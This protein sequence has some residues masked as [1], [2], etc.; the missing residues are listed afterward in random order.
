LFKKK[1]DKKM[2]KIFILFFIITA[3]FS[4]TGCVTASGGRYIGP[5]PYE[6]PL[7]QVMASNLAL[8]CPGDIFVG[9]PVNRC[10]MSLTNIDTRFLGYPM[11]SG[12]RQLSRAEKIAIISASGAAIGGAVRGWRG[13]A[14]GGAVGAVAAT[15]ATNRSRQTTTQT[16]TK[17]PV[18]MVNNYQSR[19]WGPGA[20][21]RLIN[22]LEVFGRELTLQNLTGDPLRVFVEGEYNSP[23]AV[24][25]PRESACA[26]PGLRYEAQV[27]QTAVDAAGWVGGTQNVPRKPEALPG[28]RLVWR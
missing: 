4:A 17:E 24:L 28:L 27:I 20:A 2:K 8:I 9:P 11:Y 7:G 25:K 1:G 16:T 10:L 19:L 3:A 23:V 14:I 13:A 22:C 6:G 5:L 21:P 15:M 26:D 18:V 12:E